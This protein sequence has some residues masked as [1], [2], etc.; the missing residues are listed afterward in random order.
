MSD[1]L[2]LC[3]ILFDAFESA[4]ATEVLNRSSSDVYISISFLKLYFLSFFFQFQNGRVNSQLSGDYRGNDFTA[5]LT[6]ANI[7]IV[8]RSGKL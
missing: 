5:A 7:D 2:H 6:A 1:F 3:R 8:K 4:Q